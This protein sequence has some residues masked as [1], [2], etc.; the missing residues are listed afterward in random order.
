MHC[1]CTIHTLFMGPTT[2]LFRKKNIKNGSH[3][4]IHTFKN[5]F[6]TVFSIFNKISCIQ[7]DSTSI[8]Q[9][10]Q[11]SKKENTQCICPSNQSLEE[12]HLQVLDQYF[13]FF[14]CP[15]IP[16][17]P[18]TPHQTVGNHIPKHPIFMFPKLPDQLARR[19]NTSLGITQN[20][21]K[22]VTTILHNSLAIR[23]CRSK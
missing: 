14:K 7:T 10:R 15:G 3:G 4:T 19:S 11:R 20:I 2:T 23:Q 16:F 21:P 18:N 13:G 1:S 9:I 22:S 8:K 6:A 17:P 12:R 5:Y